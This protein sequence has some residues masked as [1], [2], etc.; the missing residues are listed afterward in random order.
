MWTA[1]VLAATVAVAADLDA[2]VAEAAGAWRIARRA[3]R[4]FYY[5]PAGEYAGALA[6]PDRVV[7]GDTR[8]DADL[9]ERLPSYA[10]FQ[11]RR[12]PARSR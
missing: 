7:L 9:P 12:N 10:E 4:F 8:I 2:E 3:I 5:V 6:N 1:L 11:A